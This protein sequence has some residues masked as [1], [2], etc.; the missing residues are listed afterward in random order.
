METM[1]SDQVGVE[2]PCRYAQADNDGGAWYGMTYGI[3]DEEAMAMSD[4]NC[5]CNG[6]AL[7]QVNCH[8]EC[9]AYKDWQTAMAKKK[10]ALKRKMEA[11]RE[12]AGYIKAAQHREAKRRRR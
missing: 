11:D 9:T 2:K 7:R 12:A 6:C 8:G 5:P 1:D 10:K 3:C 4:R